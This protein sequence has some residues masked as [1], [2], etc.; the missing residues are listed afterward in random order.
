M[1][2][3]L[4]GPLPHEVE[5]TTVPLPWGQNLFILKKKKDDLMTTLSTSTF[6]FQL[7]VMI[8]NLL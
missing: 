1:Y 7:F 8:L 4:G 3:Q 5:V 6:K 2:F